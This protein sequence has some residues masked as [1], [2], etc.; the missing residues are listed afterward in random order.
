MSASQL[1]LHLA[2]FAAAPLGVALLLALAHRLV[3]PRRPLPGGWPGAATLVALAGLLAQAAAVVVQGRD[4]TMAGW[5]A[6]LLASAS[7][8][9]LLGRHWRD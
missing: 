9:W 4:G 1:A 6:L 7:M 3:W 2:A 8:L 5:A